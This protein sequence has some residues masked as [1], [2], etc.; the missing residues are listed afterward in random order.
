MAED[1][2]QKGVTGSQLP[3]FSEVS[4]GNQLQNEKTKS[5]IGIKKVLKLETQSVNVNPLYTSVGYVIAKNMTAQPTINPRD[6]VDPY[7]PYAPY[8]SYGNF[9]NREYI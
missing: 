9:W 2:Q 4:A 7:D 6:L 3:R 5:L 8:F 1:L